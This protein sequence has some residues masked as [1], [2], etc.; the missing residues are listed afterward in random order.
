M[1]RAFK[2]IGMIFVVATA[3]KLGKVKGTIDAVNAMCDSDDSLTIKIDKT[4]ITVE[5]GVNNGTSNTQM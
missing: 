5:T 2:V 3:Y 1:A 4:G